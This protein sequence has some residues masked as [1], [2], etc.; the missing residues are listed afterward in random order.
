MPAAQ[1]RIVVTNVSVSVTPRN[2]SAARR[3]A[4]FVPSGS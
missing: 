4:G 3:S 1:G 2:W